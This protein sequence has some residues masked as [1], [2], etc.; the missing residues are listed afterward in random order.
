[1]PVRAIGSLLI[2]LIAPAALADPMSDLTKDGN[3]VC[4]RRDYDAAHLKKNSSQQVTSMTVWIAGKDQ[5]RSGNTGLA[6]TRRGDRQPLFLAGDCSWGNFDGPPN[7]MPSFRKSFGAGCVTLAVPDVFTNVSSAKEGG[8]VI[9][10]PAADGKTM[11][12]HLDGRQSLVKR[13]DREDEIS[14]K[15]GAADRVF[16]VRRV[17]AKVCDFLK[18][19]LTTLEPGPEL[20][21]R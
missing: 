2:A 18:E 5:M 15:L 11:M 6:L 21:A 20:R 9:L 8:G 7:W 3:A 13:G 17:D 12:V 14:V 4:F 19:A 10:D 16:L 1:M